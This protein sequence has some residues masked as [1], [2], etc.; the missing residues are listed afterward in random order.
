MRRILALITA[1]ICA[2]PPVAWSAAVPGPQLPVQ[3]SFAYRPVSGRAYVVGEVASPGSY[4]MLA[5]SRLE[6]AL[7]QAGGIAARGSWRRIE[8]RSGGRKRF[9]DLLR[10]RRFGEERQNPSIDAG[11][12]VFVPLRKKMVSVLGAV[13]NPGLYELLR[14]KSVADLLALAGGT[15]ALLAPVQPYR[16]VRVHGEGRETVSVAP[17]VQTM[18]RTPIQDGDVLYVPERGKKGLPKDIA[19]LPLPEME[20]VTPFQ[21]N[22]VYVIGGVASPGPYP[23]QPY[24]QVSHYVAEA[25]GFA[26]G[27]KARRMQLIHFDGKKKRIAYDDPIR[28]RPGDTINV[29]EKGMSSGDWTKIVLGVVGVGLSTTATILSLTR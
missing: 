24:S 20:G 11:D 7:Q 26:S 29:P 2:L 19:D 15:S 8:V 9:A 27:A 6:D 14:E 3:E 4:V 22:F 12:V 25:G 17:G 16:I 21:E 5:G 23:Y 10:F 13:S 18:Q 28:P 1:L